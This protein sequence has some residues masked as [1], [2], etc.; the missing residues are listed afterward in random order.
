MLPLLP[1]LVL[2]TATLAEPPEALIE[3]LARSAT[4]PPPAVAPAN[5][6]E[7]EAPAPP[8]PLPADLRKEALE[9]YRDTGIAPVIY[10][11]HEAVHPWGQSVPTLTCAPLNVCSI[12]LEPGEQIRDIAAGDPVRW[13]IATATSGEPPT[14]HLIVKP[15]ELDLATNLF[16]TTQRRTYS[17]ELRS[18]SLTQTKKPGFQID[19]S[20]SFYYPADFVRQIENHEALALQASEAA[21]RLT[22]AELSTELSKLNFDYRIRPAGSKRP[23]RIF[24]D[25]LRT[26]IQ[27][28]GPGE[29]GDAPALLAMNDEGKPIAV[30]FRPSQDAT[31]FVVD[32]V[33][34]RLQLIARSGR[35]DLKVEIVNLRHGD[36]P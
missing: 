12:H 21:S 32:G 33:F 25:G 30:N 29:P 24:D 19:R 22:L 31:W 36:R 16:V 7:A 8:P 2:A 9:T 27:L 13:Q 23:L 11:T 34:P 1:A 5:G 6:F 26:Y 18:P 28:R 15:T 4:Q 3:D 35:R 10:Q 17:I 20:L 14:P